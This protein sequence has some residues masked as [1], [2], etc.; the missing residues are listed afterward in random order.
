MITI[1][2]TIKYLKQQ[3]LLFVRH[4]KNQY[5]KTNTYKIKLQETQTA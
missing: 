4:K 3:P 1:K 5:N 2:I